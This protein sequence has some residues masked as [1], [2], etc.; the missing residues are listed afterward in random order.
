MG[1]T[2]GALAERS[3]STPNDCS[4]NPIIG[5]IFISFS[6]SVNFV[7][8]SKND[9]NQ[10]AGK[11]NFLKTNIQV[12]KLQP[13]FPKV[14]QNPNTSLQRHRL[15]LVVHRNIFLLEASVRQIE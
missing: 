4:L 6:M 13:E 9:N 10:K 8:N 12:L 5:N 15:M 11:A 14:F 7:L 2:S 1:R 3:L